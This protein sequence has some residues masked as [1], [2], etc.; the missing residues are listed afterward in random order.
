MTIVR[1]V[2]RLMPRKLAGVGEGL[3]L[4][5]LGPTGSQFPSDFVR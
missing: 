4:A 5:D 1:I 3:H 2:E